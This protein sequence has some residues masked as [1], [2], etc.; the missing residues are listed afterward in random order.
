MTQHLITIT[1]ADLDAL[2]S[3]VRSLRDEVRAI[4]RP[5]PE[6][7]PIAEYAARKKCSVST[8]RRKIGDGVL[9]CRYEGKLREVWNG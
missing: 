8:V 4:I 7:L 9:R 1:A 3:E 6:W 5:E 2:T